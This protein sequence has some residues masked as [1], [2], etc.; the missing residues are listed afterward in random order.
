MNLRNK[1][2]WIVFFV[3][4]T[5]VIWLPPLAPS[6]RL[7]FFAPY[8]II[9]LYKHPF[10]RCLW[11]S[12][13]C[14][15]LVDLFSSYQHLGLTGLNYILSISILYSQRRNFFSDRPS[16]LPIM[17]YLFSIISSLI[18]LPILLIFEHRISISSSW[19]ISDIL[20]MPLLD[21]LYAFSLYVAPFW[22]FGKPILKGEDY[23][24]EK[25]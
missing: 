15:I 3:S 9:C 14:G 2:L 24:T 18:Q 8:L 6:I 12:L 5:L 1:N 19:I 20:L 17:V 16:T 23:F 11:A 13:S 7:F 25:E 22:I 4:L 10:I 21:A